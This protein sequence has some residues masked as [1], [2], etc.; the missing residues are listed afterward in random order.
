MRRV[1]FRRLT[2]AVAIAAALT[3][4]ATRQPAPSPGTPPA[5]D[6][7]VEVSVPGG[8]TGL[9]LE[10]RPE[11]IISLN[12]SSTEV[13]YAVGAGK[14]VVAVDDQSTF[15]AEAP[16]TTLSGF[17]PN[18]EAIANHK[19]DL[20]LASNDIDN[21]VAGLGQLKIQVLL[22]PPAKTLDEAFTQVSAVG[23]AT[24]HAAAGE[25]LAQRMRTD[26]DKIVAETRKSA[27]PL[28][29]YHEL[30]NSLYSVSSKTFVGHVYA[31]FG[32]VNIADDGDKSG[33][34]YPQLSA[35]YLVKA[36]PDL[37]FL[38]DTKCCAQN[39]QSVAARP[40]WQT[41]TAVKN[42]GVIA[43][44]DDIASRWGPRVVDLVRTVSSAVSAAAAK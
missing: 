31:R 33:S 17:K 39:A 41:V 30:D 38:A 2:A 24:G 16:K 7:P 15:P 14:Q 18:L 28:S 19:P 27:K 35:E 25:A 9:K 21:L 10:K 12:P 8:S 11:R 40:G 43:L 3:G 26:I 1:L 4:C 13:L 42:N 22:V 5:A 20:V 29:Y 36:N 34:G 44:D 32:L 37:I 6:F 23:K